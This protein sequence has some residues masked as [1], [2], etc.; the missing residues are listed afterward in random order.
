MFCALYYVTF[1]FTAIK[2]HSPTRSGV[3]ML[4]TT[5]LLLPGSII[6]SLVTTRIGRYRWAIW[7]G[8]AVT[9]L[10]CG[11]L[12][13][14][15]QDTA[16]PVWATVLAVF[17][18]GNG[19]LLTGVNVGVQAVSRV[20]DA[21]RAA[22]MYAFTRT[23]GMSIGVAVGG[24]VFQ[25]A[26]AR[27]L[28]ELGLAEGMAHDAEAFVGTVARM[29]PADPTRVGAVQA[30]RFIIISSWCYTRLPGDSVLTTE[31]SGS[32]VAGFHG[33]YWLITGAAIGAFLCS[34]II[35]RHSMDKLLESRFV[36]NKGGSSPDSSGTSSMAAGDSPVS[37]C[38][39]SDDMIRTVS[40][41]AANS[42][43]GSEISE[44]PPTC[45]P[46]KCEVSP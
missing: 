15:D 27:R 3:D 8:W 10:A 26:M 37:D 31:I 14:F 36:L 16:T 45:D 18:V 20:E 5:C 38:V 19:M 9:A 24:T 33:V 7:S 41:L 44:T 43:G 4:P 34:L 35:K 1:Y 17:G 22:A 30:C 39:P 2:F 12:A 23:L 29:D 11:L 21:G 6:V 32:D 25:N 46:Q 40:Q 13:L 28:A 42:N